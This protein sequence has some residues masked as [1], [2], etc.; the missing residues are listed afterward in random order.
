MFPKDVIE[1]AVIAAAPLDNTARAGFLNQG[2]D[3]T[4]GVDQQ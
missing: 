4:V 2:I 1:Y 3:G